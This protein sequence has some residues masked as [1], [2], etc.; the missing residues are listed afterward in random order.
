MPTPHTVQNSLRDKYAKLLHQMMEG[1]DIPCEFILPDGD[2]YRFGEN[3]PMFKV[4]FHNEKAL[5]RG[6]DEYS[7]G[8]AYVEG[9]IDFEGDMMAMLDLRDQM[10]NKA[11]LPI[12]LRLWQLL[13]FHRDTAVNKK[14][15]ASHYNFGDEFYLSFI[16]RA[17]RFYSHCNFYA[18]DETNE[19]AAEHKLEIMYDALKLATGKRLLDIGAGWGGVHEYCGQR[20][21]HVTSVTLTQDSYNYTNALI[22]R[23]NLSDTC[24]VYIEDFLEHQPK[25][26][27]D[28]IVIYGVIE[29]IPY[30]RRFFQQVHAC[31]KPNGLFYLDASATKEMYK[32]SDF[33]R[34]YIWTGTHTFMCLQ[35]IIQELLFN[36]LD[37]LEV[38]NDS[39]DYQLTMWH[40][41][42]RF[43]EKH[44]FI[45]KRWGEEVYR[46]FRVYLW[47]GCHAFKIDRLQAYHLVAR[48]STN[49]GPRPNFFRRTLHFI[50]NVIR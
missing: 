2:S 45:V 41:A 36:G 9:D 26:L 31:L 6:F 32:M 27:Y 29:H 4:T 15:I 39:H 34:T 7:L 35:E 21:V 12:I 37:L 11:N 25:E 1:T 33:T 48:K 18:D 49:M 40:W 8:K 24:A 22:Q 19:Q 14:S 50:R 30:Y 28:G 38:K 42:T 47:G 10:Q 23:L 43:D 20:G 16:D 5:R 17:Y 46:A 13:L 3:K 44:D